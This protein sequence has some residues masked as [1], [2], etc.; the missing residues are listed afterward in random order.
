MAGARVTIWAMLWQPIE[1]ISIGATFRSAATVALDGHTEYRATA[2]HIRHTNRAA[3]AD[4][5]FPLT[6]V[7]GVSYRPTPKWNLE[8]DADY[9]DWSSFGTDNHLP[10]SPP[11]P[12]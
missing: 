1:K 7:F 8:F 3:K 4:F 9:T 10:I 11:R 2:L 6:V 5:E 12:A